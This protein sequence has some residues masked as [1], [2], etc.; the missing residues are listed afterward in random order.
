MNIKKIKIFLS[1]YVFQGF[2]ILLSLLL[3]KSIAVIFPPQIFGEY[4]LITG[5]MAIGNSFFFSPLIHSFRYKFQ[6]YKTFYYLS[7]Y[8]SL[9]FWFI[10]TISILT[11]L[12]SSI[13]SNYNWIILTIIL[14]L[15][16]QYIQEL[17]NSILNLQEKH[18]HY[19]S[20]LLLNQ[21]LTLFFFHSI[22]YLQ[23]HPN[24]NTLLVSQ[25]I[26]FVVGSYISRRQ[27][28]IE[29]R[30]KIWKPNQIFHSKLFKNYINFIKPLI[31]LPIFT[32]T[33]N[34]GDKFLITYFINSDATGLYSASYSI[35]SKIFLSMNAPL[36][37]ILNPL[38]YSKKNINHD[39]I[40]VQNNTNKFISYYLFIGAIIILFLFA[41]YYPIGNFL[42][43]SNYESAFKLIPITG[44]SYLFITTSF[45]TEQILYARGKTN[46]LLISFI[47]G[48][49]VNITSN[50]ILIPIKGI[51]GAACAMVISTF[52]QMLFENI[53]L[54]KTKIFN[55]NS[56]TKNE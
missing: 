1:L 42:L 48:S 31:I 13:S 20:I 2:N 21:I 8:K 25:L 29:Q 39:D 53:L 45:F 17:N 9:I 52:T 28:N 38:I 6:E 4:T 18:S 27:L 14:L 30:F 46:L 47:V 11:L 51:E 33:I 32:W 56:I 26:S 16:F 3:G 19:S 5:L 44:L 41:T 34:Q 55:K 43:S 35:G 24:V 22:S 12:I 40:S 37:L 10:I 54:R 23:S 15:L 36:L 50:L 49:V 7:F